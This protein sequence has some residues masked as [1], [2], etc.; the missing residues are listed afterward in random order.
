MFLQN[1][2]IAE[3][4]IENQGSKSEQQLHQQRQLKLNWNSDELI[5]FT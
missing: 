5:N 2:E 3:I 1:R 4:L